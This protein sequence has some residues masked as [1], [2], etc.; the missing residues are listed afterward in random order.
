VRN[1][2]FFLY[3]LA[4]G[5]LLSRA[6]ATDYEVIQ[7]MFLFEGFQLYGFMGVAMAIIAPGLVLLQRHGKTA[8]GEPLVIE[9]KPAHGGNIAGGVLFGVG[10]A[11]TGMCPAPILVN[12]GEGKVYALAAFAGTVAGTWLLGL[13]Y[14]R[15][16]RPLGLEPLDRAPAGP[17]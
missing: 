3:A 5:F 2:F 9:R 8:S 17:R 16:Q 4:F 12:L 7:Q 11:M 15:L 13:L 10:W 14:E 6:G 1:L